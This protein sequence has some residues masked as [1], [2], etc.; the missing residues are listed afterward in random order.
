MLDIKKNVVRIKTF[1]ISLLVLIITNSAFCQEHDFGIWYGLN[2]KLSLN[3]KYEIDLSAMIRT[4]DNGSQ[5][6]Q[7]FMEGGI[8]C[9][10]SKYFSVAGSYRITN[11][12]EDNS[13]Y[14]IRHKFLIDAKG[15]LPLNDFTFST[16][17]RLQM[18]TR[19]YIE[20]VGD[21][22]S[23]YTCRVR[24]K[25]L[26]NIPK[27]PVNPYVCFESFSPLFENS[28]RFIEKKRY[29]AGFEYKIVKKHSIE[30]EYIFERDFLPRLSDISIAS[31]SYNLKF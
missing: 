25:C 19:T 14:H 28:E 12:L 1:Y 26:Y 7:A 23:N 8:A 24:F 15:S 4:I 3:K 13:E 11:N 30:A 9:K 2:T 22:A 18:Q 27:F 31:V 20:D 17:L 6:D 10:F 16:R 5:I 21:K 29:T